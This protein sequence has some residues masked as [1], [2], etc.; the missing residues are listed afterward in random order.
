MKRERLIAIITILISVFCLTGLTSAADEETGEVKLIN[1]IVV[2]QTREGLSPN[3][4]VSKPGTTVIWVNQSQ[5]PAEI[6]FTDKKVTLI[7][8]LHLPAVLL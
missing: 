7:K 2:V 4:L 3:T 6:L 8:K 1:K 5:Q